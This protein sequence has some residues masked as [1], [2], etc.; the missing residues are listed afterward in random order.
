MAISK[1]IGANPKS[2]IVTPLGIIAAFVALSETVAGLAAINTDGVVQVIFAAFATI[3]PCFVAMVFFRVLWHRSY[4][5]YPPQDFGAEVDVRHYVDAMRHQAVSSHELHELVRTT[6]AETLSSKEAH[7]A[8]SSMATGKPPIPEALNAATAVL[9]AHAVDRL[10]LSVLTVDVSEFESAT[11][12]ELV[13]RYD[14]RQDAFEFLTAVYFQISD[15]V[16]AFT[17]GKSWA[18]QDTVSGSLML[19]DTINWADNHALRESGATVAKMGFRAGMRLRAIPLKS[20][21]SR[22]VK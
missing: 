6:I 17:Y 16:R 22:L 8:L 4:V 7:S 10:E 5:F 1:K 3:F 15:H 20:D 13:F 11:V 12:P 14:G 19:P 2:A 21:G 9:A 18:L